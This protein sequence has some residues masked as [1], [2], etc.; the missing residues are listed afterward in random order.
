[1][2]SSRRPAFSPAAEGSPPRGIGHENLSQRLKAA[3]TRNDAAEDLDQFRLSLRFFRFVP[4]IV[5]DCRQAQDFHL[6][7]AVW[8]HDNGFIADLFVQ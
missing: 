7:L 5:V 2:A 1:M 6:A 4:D 8:S 3:R